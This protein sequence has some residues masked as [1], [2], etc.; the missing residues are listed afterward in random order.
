MFGVDPQELIVLLVVAMVVIGPERLPQ[1]AADFAKFIR[2]ARDFAF[3]AREQVR[4]EMGEEFNDVDW[5]ALDPR[6][7]DPRRIVRDAL[8]DD[9]PDPF[10]LQSLKNDTAYLL[11]D[12]GP[13]VPA[14]M[15]PVPL[16]PEGLI[17]DPAAEG[18]PA[19]SATP[20]ASTARPASR[21][22][23]SFDLDAT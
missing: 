15:R 21:P 23:G 14:P 20:A 9:G 2:Q 7:Y 12:E 3:K 16:P 11:S 1:Y 4:S 19:A 13:H 6:R 10:G 18:G 17:A 5:Q 8:R 22:P